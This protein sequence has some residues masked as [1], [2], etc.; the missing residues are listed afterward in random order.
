[1]T[2]FGTAGS[3]SR[4]LDD[5]FAHPTSPRVRTQLMGGIPNARDLASLRALQRHLTEGRVQIKRSVGPSQRTAS[6]LPCTTLGRGLRL[7]ISSRTRTRVPAQPSQRPGRD[8][9]PR[10]VSRLRLD[11]YVEG[12]ADGAGSRSAGGHDNRTD[13]LP[14]VVLDVAEEGQCCVQ[15]PA[16][17]TVGDVELRGERSSCDRALCPAHV[18]SRLFSP[19]ALHVHLQARV[20]VPSHQPATCRCVR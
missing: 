1:V 19:G 16:R 11:P 17:R 13:R 15:Q 18:A 9:Q 14:V 2:T 3:T 10:P 4:G 12:P 8:R 20:R 5:V 6:G 7:S